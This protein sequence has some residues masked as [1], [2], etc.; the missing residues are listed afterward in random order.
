VGAEAHGASEVG[1]VG[2]PEQLAWLGV[3]APSGK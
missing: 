1:G 2:C 3:N